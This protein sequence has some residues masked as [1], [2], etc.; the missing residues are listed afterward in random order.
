MP[1]PECQL[2]LQWW[3]LAQLHVLSWFLGSSSIDTRHLPRH[4]V[5]PLKINSRPTYGGTCTYRLSGRIHSIIWKVTNVFWVKELRTRNPRH[6]VR[7][8]RAAHNRGLYIFN[9]PPST[10][11]IRGAISN[12]QDFGRQLF[13]NGL[14]SRSFD[15]ITPRY[16]RHPLSY[17]GRGQVNVWLINQSIN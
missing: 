10:V 4:D 8:H 2:V 13:V 5:T 6:R 15:G 12:F 7:L 16:G 17:G 1:Q 9:R 3:L 14:Q 11:I